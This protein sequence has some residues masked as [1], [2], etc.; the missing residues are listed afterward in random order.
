MRFTTIVTFIF[1]F[2]SATLTF[3]QPLESFENLLEANKVGKVFIKKIG[4]DI[5]QT[6]FLG[7]IKDEKGILNNYVVNKFLK[8]QAANLYHGNSSILFFNNEK[9]LVKEAN[10]SLPEELP[11][12]LK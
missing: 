9:K 1:L 4:S 8:V 3:S 2:F 6:T 11:F 7:T 12:K 5:S 10:L